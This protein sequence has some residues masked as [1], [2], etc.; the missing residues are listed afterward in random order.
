MGGVVHGLGRAPKIARTREPNKAV[1]QV[2]PLQQKEDDKDD[3]D[4]SRRQRLEQRPGDLQDQ[5]DWGRV[6]WADLDGDGLLLLGTWR[7]APRL[8]SGLN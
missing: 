1:S 8:G 2:L 7:E 5:L 4:A 6:G 3:D